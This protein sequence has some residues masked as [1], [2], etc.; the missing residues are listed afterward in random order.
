MNFL[1][2][3]LCFGLSLRLLF[4]E[5]TKELLEFIKIHQTIIIHSR[6]LSRTR[7][8]FFN[9]NC[10]IFSKTSNVEVRFYSQKF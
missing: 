6:R 2:K 1:T 10:G 5:L 8:Y 9:V 3:L 4:F 7:G